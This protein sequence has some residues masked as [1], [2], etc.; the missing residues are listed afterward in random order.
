MAFWLKILVVPVEFSLDPIPDLQFFGCFWRPVTQHQ[1][2]VA[3]GS[4]TSSQ[5]IARKD[6]Q[7]AART[8]VKS[9]GY[10]KRSY[11]EDDK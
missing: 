11:K 8:P 5:R 1:R 6:L 2:D 7:D 9:T 3:S 10:H 4:T